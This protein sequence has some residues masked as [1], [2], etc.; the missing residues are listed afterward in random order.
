MHFFVLFPSTT[1]YHC[2]SAVYNMMKKYSEVASLANIMGLDL[3]RF[4]TI[5]E[6]VA[7]VCQDIEI[8]TKDK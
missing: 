6:K 1:V 4:S 7:K 2:L 3:Q 8:V 5:S